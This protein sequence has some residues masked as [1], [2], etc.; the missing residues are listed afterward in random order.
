MRAWLGAVS[1]GSMVSLSCGLRTDPLPGSPPQPS[2]APPTSNETVAPAV[3]TEPPPL[4]TTSPPEPNGT[5]TTGPGFDV[6]TSEVTTFEATTFGFEP[7]TFGSEATWVGPETLDPD[8]SFPFPLAPDGSFCAQDFECASDRCFNFAGE[9]GGTCGECRNDRDCPWGCSR[10]APLF[11]EGSRCNDGELGAGCDVDAS[12][13]RPLVCSELSSPLFGVSMT[14]CSECDTHAECFEGA[15]TPF[16]DLERLS[17]FKICVP[18]QSLPV[19]S[20]CDPTTELGSTACE[21]GICA[22][23]QVFGALV[24]ICS[25]C[26]EDRPCPEPLTCALPDAGFLELFPGTCQ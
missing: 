15:C 2:R 8:P 18:R 5:A 26:T 21:S 24:G 23:L 25:E 22:P 7:T 4:Q 10:P 20:T 11:F 14:G 3:T 19:G 6:T 1:V 17:G 9:L 16:L 13:Q 12:C